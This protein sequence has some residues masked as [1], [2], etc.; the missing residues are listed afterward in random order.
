[1]YYVIDAVRWGPHGHISHV[2]WHA[3]DA[4]E[5]DD[6]TIAHAASQV[7]PVVDAAKVCGSSE[8]RVM[9]T[10]SRRASSR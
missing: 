6:A 10:V 3:V 7:V 9:S 8:V 1:M 4:V 2:R 5:A